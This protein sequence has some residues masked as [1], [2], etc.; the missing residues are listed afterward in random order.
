MQVQFAYAASAAV[1]VARATAAS[2]ENDGGASAGASVAAA[3]HPGCA[4]MAG[5]GEHGG[6]SVS[7]LVAGSAARCM[8]QVRR[9]RVAN[10]RAAGFGAI[11]TKIKKI[12]PGVSMYGRMN[13]TGGRLAR[14]CPLRSRAANL[15][16]DGVRTGKVVDFAFRA[17][18]NRTS[19]TAGLAPAKGSWD[20]GFAMQQGQYEDR[21][22]TPVPMDVSFAHD[23]LCAVADAMERA[24]SIDTPKMLE[25]MP[26]ARFDN[27]SVGCVAFGGEGDLKEGAIAIH[28]FKDSGTAVLEAVGV[29]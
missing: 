23:V 14:Q 22:R 19:S 20:A 15:D 9:G 4:R 1:A 10:D 26:S 5:N 18:G 13:A 3:E 16:G 2:N 8:P 17:K 11:L 21:F 7:E 24:V 25:A 12:Q 29:Q 6:E 28:D 27:G